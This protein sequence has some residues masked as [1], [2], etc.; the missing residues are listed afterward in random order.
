[1]TPDTEST[2]VPLRLGLGII[3]C[4]VLV[5]AGIG[6]GTATAQET[7]INVT[8]AGD[9][10]TD[11]GTHVVVEDPTVNI[12]A[13]SA[14]PIDLVEIRV[15]GEIRHSY[16]PDARS[17]EQ[18]VSLDLDL[19][20]NTVEVIVRAD[21][22]NTFTT[23][24]TKNTAAPRVR[25]TS[26]FSTTVLGGPENQTTVSSGQVTLAGNLHTVTEVDQIQIE[27]T[28]IGEGTDGS[29][30]TRKLYQIDDPGSSFSQDL[31]L[32]TGR[33]NIVARY[34]DT[35]GRTNK[36]SFDLIVDDGTDPVINFTAPTE[37]YT[38]SAR[39]R[40][41]VRDETK[42]SRVAIGRA[43]NNASQVLLPGSNTEPDR[44]RLSYTIDTT[45]DLYN[46]NENNKFR[47]VA[48][49]AAGNTE[50]QT[51]IVKYDPT[52][53]ITISKNT[54][55]MTA[56]T[57]RL[58][59]N[60]SNA[61][62]SRITLE[63]IDTR[64]GE[65]LDI[66]RVYDAGPTITTVAFNQT[67]RAVPG[68]TVANVLVTYENGQY[69]HSVKPSVS[70]SQDNG[71]D[72]EAST[73]NSSTT[74]NASNTNQSKPGNGTDNIETANESGAASDDDTDDPIDNATES[75][76]TLIPLRTREAFGG[77]VIVGSIYLLGHWV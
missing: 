7:T 25:Y 67:L 37:S 52:P 48:E 6:M 76:P 4:V 27:R 63:T 60:V 34:T 22:V 30:Q 21:E 62:I 64:S 17:F 5:S 65:R 11:G 55:N 29:N 53:D 3:F 42:L 57:V 58:A 69:T 19:N 1:M 20:E 14:K 38:G 51:F 70:T 28:H 68:E 73:A 59:G 12:T 54:T 61:R 75:S 41:T 33:N 40:G 2:N 16:R 66:T 8:A 32:G 13:S 46:D 10:L 45:V 18:A 23:T 24:L 39:I 43:S 77:V 31:L 74:E 15:D 71:T 26:P 9:P 35:N 47:L 49:D 56:G 50:E 72:T 36:D 44:D